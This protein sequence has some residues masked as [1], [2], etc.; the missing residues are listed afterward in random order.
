M[1]F[2]A[3][4]SR[5]RA[6]LVPVQ[7]RRAARDFHQRSLREGPGQAHGRAPWGRFAKEALET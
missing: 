4:G 3:P 1:H 7:S 5:S 6:Q 2:N